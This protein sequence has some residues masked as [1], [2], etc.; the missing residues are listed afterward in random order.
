VPAVDG[1]VGDPQPRDDVGQVPAGP[2]AE[3]GRLRG[4]G[5][6]AT[7]SSGSSRLS[8]PQLPRSSAAPMARA[9]QT[10]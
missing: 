5:Q 4:G 1:D 2:L 10:A 8:G 6:E 3:N 9:R 7:R